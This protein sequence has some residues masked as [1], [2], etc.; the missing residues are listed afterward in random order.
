METVA[1]ASSPRGE[2]VLRRR[3][4]GHL[5]LRANGVFVM[6]TLEHTSERALADHA[7]ELADCDSLRVLVGGL[8]LGFTLGAVLADPR[9]VRCTVAEIEPD[10]VGWL[11][12]G[13]VP[14]G[15]ALLADSRVDVQIG[16]V[17]DVLRAAA[18]AYD[19]VLLD[20]DNGPG[21]L[22][23]DTNA[24]LYAEPALVTAQAALAPGGSLV[25]WSAARA[26]ELEHALREVFGNAEEQSYDVPGHGRVGQY[27]VYTARR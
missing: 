1:R 12:D 18:T 17:A 2:L 4:D 25:I 22:V 21:Y 5:E 20:V 15:P 10:L 8:G 16:D 9:V 6:D 14:H 26:S 11:R 13:T 24:A 23:H 27:F 3:D 7:L 19:V